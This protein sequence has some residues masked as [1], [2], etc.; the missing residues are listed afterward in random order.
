M[1]PRE[2]DFDWDDANV[3]H[4]ADHSVTPTEAEDA[5]LDPARLFT[6]DRSTPTER[7]R[8]VIGAT[9]AGRILFVSYTIRR[10]A[11]RVVTAFDASNAQ[12]RRYRHEKGRS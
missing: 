8:G 1:E 5:I 3:E 7:R 6:A 12:K 4:I 11:Y 9:D 10:G 2:P